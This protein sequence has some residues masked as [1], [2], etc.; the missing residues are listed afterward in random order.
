LL[1]NGIFSPVVVVDGQ[2]AGV[3]TKT[4]KKDAIHIEVNMLTPLSEANWKKL[5]LTTRRY[6]KFYGKE[7]IIDS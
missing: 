1:R 4:E 6:A 7:V 5:E 3:W 2:V